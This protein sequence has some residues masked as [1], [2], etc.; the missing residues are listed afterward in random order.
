MSISTAVQAAGGTSKGGRDEALLKDAAGG[1][2]SWEAGKI[3]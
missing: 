2:L 1:R 3:R